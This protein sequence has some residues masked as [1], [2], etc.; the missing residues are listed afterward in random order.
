V[1]ALVVRDD[2][3]VTSERPPDG[4][5]SSSSRAAL[6]A[7]DDAAVHP[8]QGQERA[9]MPPPQFADAQAE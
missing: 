7:S 6:P 9:I 3:R 1:G 4:A 2:G 8:E 5:K